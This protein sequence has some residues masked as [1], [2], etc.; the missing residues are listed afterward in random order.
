MENV[1]KMAGFGSI[2]QN[3]IALDTQSATQM[4]VVSNARTS[5]LEKI[6]KDVR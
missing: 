4:V 3:V 2:V 6:V 5:L 1:K